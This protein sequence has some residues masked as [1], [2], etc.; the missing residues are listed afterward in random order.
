MRRM[1]HFSIYGNK[2]K[3]KQGSQGNHLTRKSKR[4]FK[5]MQIKYRTQFD[6]IRKFYFFVY[7]WF[8]FLKK[9]RKGDIDLH[10][11]KNVVYLSFYV[12][13]FKRKKNKE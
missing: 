5:T 12:S 4:L 11:Q 8:F 2:R 6:K 13:F 3:V 9:K 1:P 7:S 10:T